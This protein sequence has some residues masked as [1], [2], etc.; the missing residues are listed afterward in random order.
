MTGILTPDETAR[1]TM[2]A[3]FGGRSGWSWRVIALRLAIA[4][5]AV[6]L[7]GGAFGLLL[8]IIFPAPPEPARAPFGMSAREMPSQGNVLANSILA[9]QA[10][11]TNTC[12]APCGT[13]ARSGAVFWT[14]DGVVL[15][16]ASSLISRPA[17]ASCGPRS[18]SSPDDAPC[19]V[20]SAYFSLRACCRPLVAIVMIE[21]AIYLL[22]MTEPG[23]NGC[24]GGSEMASFAIRG[25]ARA[26]SSLAQGRGHYLVSR[27]GA[28]RRQ[29]LVR[30]FRVT[31]SL[32][33]PDNSSVCGARRIFW[34]RL[35][36]GAA[37]CAVPLISARL[38][39]HRRGWIGAGTGPSLPCAGHERSRPAS[40]RSPLLHRRRSALRAAGAAAP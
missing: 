12:M 3:P 40:S 20:A 19:A 33:P 39:P 35:P 21:V 30:V 36:G 5:C 22:S 4:A 26:V 18:I 34:C 25:R 10:F 31:T 37:P 2:Q 7:V 24:G 17:T 32:P 6:A 8:Q 11:S 27:A 23:T 9:L 28:S 14:L 1:D 13:F 38:L 29:P 15:P 16:M